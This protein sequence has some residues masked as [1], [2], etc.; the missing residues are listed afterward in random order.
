MRFMNA[1]LLLMLLLPSCAGVSRLDK[2]PLVA[3]GEHLEKSPE[4]LYYLIRI[5]CEKQDLTPALR[6]LVRLGP[7]AEPLAITDLTPEFVSRHLPRFE[8]PREWPDAWKEKAR[9]EHAYAGGGFHIAYNDDGR[10]AFVGICS[11]CYPSRQSP[12]VGTPNGRIFYTLPLTTEQFTEVFGP[13]E[14]SRKQREVY[15]D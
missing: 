6:A 4:P 2:G 9:K 14:R 10:L 1:A 11:H 12:V 3:Y 8:P 13:A 15:R 7:E 5:N